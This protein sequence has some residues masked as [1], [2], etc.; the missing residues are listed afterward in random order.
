MRINNRLC[1]FPPRQTVEQF[2]EAG[3]VRI[4]HGGFATWLNPFRVLDAEVV[5]N[6]LAE[7]SVGV[8]LMRRGRRL[9]ERLRRL[10][11]R[12][13]YPASLVS[14]LR[15]ETNEFHKRLSIWG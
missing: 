10:A 8:D 4:T 2:H 15:S 7:L 13:L 6:L 5:V 3:L 9:D 11:R 14:A 12:F 1:G